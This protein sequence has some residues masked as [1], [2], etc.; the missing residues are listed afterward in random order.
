VGDKRNI[1]EN[2]SGKTPGYETVLK[3]GKLLEKREIA[4]K[5][6]KPYEQWENPLENWGKRSESVKL[7]S[8]SGKTTPKVGK[9]LQKWSI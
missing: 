6:G 2:F 9:P 7:P 5:M 1:V 8:R 4:R 3:V